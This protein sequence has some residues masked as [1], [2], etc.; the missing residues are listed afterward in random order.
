MKKIGIKFLAPLDYESFESFQYLLE[1]DFDYDD[2]E[3]AIMDQAIIPLDMDEEED[4]ADDL[5]VLKTLLE[6]YDSDQEQYE[7]YL[8]DQ[9]WLPSTLEELV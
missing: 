8:F 5:E 3:V 1:Y 6:A 4:R 7:L 2:L 9:A